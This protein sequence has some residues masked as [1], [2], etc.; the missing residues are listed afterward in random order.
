[1]L[2]RGVREM[3]AIEQWN[4]DNAQHLLYEYPLNSRSVVFDIGGY[5]GNWT[6]DILKRN[7]GVCGHC[8]A[9]QDPY[10]YVFEPIKAHFDACVERFK[11]YEKVWVYNHGLSNRNYE[12]DI[13]VDEAASCIHGPCPWREAGPKPTEH[14]QILDIEGVMG[15]L[16]LE[17]VDLMSINIEGEEYDLLKRM[18]ETDLMARTDNIQ[19]QFHD[20]MSNAEERRCEIQSFLKET[21]EV[22]FNYPFVWESWTKK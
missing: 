21:H 6:A 14:V 9:K 1:M 3:S 18:H 20:F 16:G 17:H 2:L 10:V 8:G 19:V 4:H 11:D 13:T 7:H 15:T 22:K 12:A 5:T